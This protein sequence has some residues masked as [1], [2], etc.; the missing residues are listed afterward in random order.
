M[1]RKIS[2]SLLRVIIVIIV[3]AGLRLKRRELKKRGIQYKKSI[4]NN[5]EAKYTYV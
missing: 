3:V 4:I 2:F 1:N 5:M